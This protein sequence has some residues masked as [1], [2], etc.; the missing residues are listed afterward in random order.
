MMYED[1]R[2]A[3]HPRFRYYALNT[4]MHWR[5]LQAGRIYI[6]QHRQD[7]HLSVEQ[8]RDMVG[9]EGQVFSYQVLHYAS[10]LRG[11][12]HYWFRQCSR[13]IANGGYSRSPNHMFHS[14]RC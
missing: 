7:R 1:G 4:E 12:R 6:Q 2:F 11:T 3:K 10:T 5:A 13:L 8:L 9:R 14:Q